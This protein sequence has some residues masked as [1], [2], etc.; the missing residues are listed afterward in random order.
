MTTT[1]RVLQG[2]VER[3][4][5]YVLSILRIMSGLLF[6]EHGTGKL[7]HFPLFHQYDVVR[8]F[9]LPGAAG[10]IELVGGSLLTLGLFTRS[11]A[12]ILSGEMAFAY[13]LY[14]APKSFFPL[15]NGGDAAILY[16]FI[17]L[18]IAVAGGGPWSV[19]RGLSRKGVAHSSA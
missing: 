10:V 7:F 2:S 17:F 19:D 1:D 8:L 5:P 13:F 12:F 15:L 9:S 18:Y 4:S 6:I 11:V 3:S 16:C 14:H